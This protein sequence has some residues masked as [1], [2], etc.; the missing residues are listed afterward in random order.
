MGELEQA[1][2]ILTNLLKESESKTAKEKASELI[3]IIESK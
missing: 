3:S 1:H 2:S